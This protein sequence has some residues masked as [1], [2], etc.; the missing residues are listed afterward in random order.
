[1]REYTVEQS[2]LNFKWTFQ[3][4]LP[5]LPTPGTPAFAEL[6]KGLHPYGITPSR[7]TVDSPSIRFGDLALGI[8][9]LLNNRLAISLT[10]QAFELFLNELLVDDEEILVPIAELVFTALRSIDTDAVQGK[11]NLRASSHLKLSVGE[12]DAVLREHTRFSEITPAFIPDAVVYKVDLGQDS[13]T[14]EL[15]V[16]I[17]KSH[18][19][20]EAIFIDISADYEGPINPAEIAEHINNDSERIM[21]ILSLKERVEQVEDKAS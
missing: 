7:V 14:K 4:M 10:S 17:A 16:V 6:C 13:K 20:Q 2:S 18:V 12:S 9:G 3:R 11:A 5:A 1:M 15:R 8:A 19:Y 21:D